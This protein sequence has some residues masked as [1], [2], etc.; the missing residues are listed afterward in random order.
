ML[1]PKMEKQGEGIGVLGALLKDLQLRYEVC[2]MVQSLDCFECHTEPMVWS[3]VSMDVS[4]ESRQ[5]FWFNIQ[6]GLDNIQRCGGSTKTS[7]AVVCRPPLQALTQG[8]GEAEVRVEA[9]R[10][11]IQRFTRRRVGCDFEAFFA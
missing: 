4:N 1:R 11:Q 6:C 3:S 5:R 7:S 9:Q 8:L 10:A 2:G